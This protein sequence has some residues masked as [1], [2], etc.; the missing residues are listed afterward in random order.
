MGHESLFLFRVKKKKSAN[1]H[2]D[3]LTNLGE[4]GLPAWSCLIWSLWSRTNVVVPWARP[5]SLF[6]F[7]SPP[8]A[9]LGQALALEKIVRV[10]PCLPGAWAPPLGSRAAGGAGG[11]SDLGWGRGCPQKTLVL[12]PELRSPP[13][14][15]CLQ[16][17]LSSAPLP[18][19][20]SCGSCCSRPLP[21]APLLASLCPGQSAGASFHA[22]HASALSPAP[23]SGAA[24]STGCELKSGPINSE[25]QGMVCTVSL[26]LGGNPSDHGGCWWFYSESLCRAS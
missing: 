10:P 24:A 5:P 4:G 17:E 19:S 12:V 9:G 1:L 2:H 7:P 14:H 25:K 26:P 11:G 21:F 16:L 6:P 23:S 22:S 15:Q 13:W 8:P 20:S 3:F 18:E